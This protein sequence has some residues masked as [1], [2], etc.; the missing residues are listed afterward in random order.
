ML[1]YFDPSKPTQLS[2]DTS[3]HGHGFILQQN[4]IGTWNL[5]QAGSQFLYNTESRYA[6]IELE[7]LA[8]CW[9]VSQCNLFLKGLQ[10]FTINT[11]HNP[12]IPSLIVTTLTN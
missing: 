6:V 3:F 7:M 9:A 5:I 1:S 8:M 10:G 2:T 12:L 4:T 11:D